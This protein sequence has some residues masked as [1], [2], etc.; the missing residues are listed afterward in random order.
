MKLS[1]GF[2]QTFK[3]TP[4][5]A[6]IPSHQLMIRAG[7]IY[8][9]SAG[10]FAYLPM[11]LRALQKVENIIRQEHAKADCYEI[12]AS[13]ITPAELWLESGRWDKME[14]QMLKMK[15]RA[16]RELCVSPTAEEA[17]VDV[18]RK[19]VSSYKQLPVCLYQINTKFRD[20]IRPRYGVMRSREF[21][22]KDAYSFH[23]NEESMHETYK[24][25]YDVYSNIWN[26]MGLKYI[27]VD[28]DG[29]TMASAGSR[30]QEFQVI[31]DSGEDRVLHCPECGYAA[32]I[33][34]AEGK[35][36]IEFSKTDK[37]IELVDTPDK[38][39]MEEVCGF[40]K[41]DKKHSLKSVVYSAITGNDEKFVLVLLVGDDELNEIKLKTLM[42]CDHL[43]PALEGDLD[44]L[45]IP[46]GFL[47]PYKIDRK[48][49][50]VVYDKAIDLSASFVTGG[51]QK[52]K[53]YLHFVPNR[54]DKEIEVSDL[55]LSN[56]G[57]HCSKCKK[58][59]LKEIKGIEV[60]QIF[61]LGDRYTKSMNVTILDQ[62]G[63]AIHPLMGCYGIGTTRTVAAAIEQ[64]NDADGIIW[65]VSIAPYHVHFVVI[66]KNEDFIKMSYEIYDQLI[67]NGIEV[68]L[69]DRNVGPGFKFKDADLL[70]LPLRL[71]LGE[72]DYAQDGMLEI[73]DRRSGKAKKIMKE[74]LIQEIKEWLLQKQNDELKSA[75][76]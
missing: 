61:E 59:I 56:A 62:N 73:R 71:T 41:V 34:A 32:N 19:Y 50:K 55:R 16:G 51:L 29:G 14:G 31:A 2:W 28:A 17:F 66:S 63:K 64:N 46:A 65:P 49:I 40:L 48:K 38:K 43:R 74:N 58:G 11:G 57:D 6:E 20:E 15:D 12:R 45:Q 10:L 72:R 24:K 42:K 76:V 26:R 8:K 3:E 47:G 25:M 13:V 22:M 35:R 39:T 5:D 70:G 69:D 44:K 23:P 53:H 9:Q 33:E 37:K 54:D 27:V 60:G 68:V 30:T 1:K 21:I 36:V 75:R 52:D 67:H 18:F 7:L 4:T